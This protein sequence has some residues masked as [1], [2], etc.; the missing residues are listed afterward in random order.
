MKTEPKTESD[1]A[2][3]CLVP[4]LPQAAVPC[5]DLEAGQH[6]HHAWLPSPLSLPMPLQVVAFLRAQEMAS[7]ATLE[8]GRVAAESLPL[9]CG[10]DEPPGLRRLKSQEESL[11]R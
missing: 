11:S 9:T 1:M 5:P 10:H 7:P 8:E 6:L 3:M 4:S 2:R